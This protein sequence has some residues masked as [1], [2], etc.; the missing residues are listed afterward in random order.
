ML[1]GIGIVIFLKQ[2]PHAFGYDAD[3]EGDLGFFQKD[4]HNTL[5]ELTVIWDFF[6]PGSCHHLG[7]ITFGTDHMGTSFCEKIYFLQTDPRS[8][9]SGEF[10]YWVELVV[11][12]LAQI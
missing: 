10:G 7:F 1:S 2:I 6:S 9:G 5:S 4:G 11:S 8:T 3:P 12:K